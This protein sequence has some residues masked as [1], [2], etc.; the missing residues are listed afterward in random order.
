MGNNEQG[1][2]RTG[3]DVEEERVGDRAH[4]LPDEGVP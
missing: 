3:G 4:V 2:A 1:G